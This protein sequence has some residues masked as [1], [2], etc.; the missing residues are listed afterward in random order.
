MIPNGDVAH[1]KGTFSQGMCSFWHHVAKWGRA[2]GPSDTFTFSCNDPFRLKEP[3]DHFGNS[4]IKNRYL[5]LVAHVSK[6][7]VCSEVIV[8]RR[9]LVE[10]LRAESSAA[11]SVPST[12]TP[13]QPG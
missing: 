13:C 5:Q 4:Y 9:G 7:T 1:V 6:F 12:V 10:T 2:Y 3:K 8:P 11:L